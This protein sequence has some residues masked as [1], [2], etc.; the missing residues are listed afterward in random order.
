MEPIV[1]ELEEKYAGEFTIVRV[2]V[3]TSA[4]KALARENGCIGTPAYMLFDDS[5]EQIRRFQGA[6]TSYTFEQEID[7]VLAE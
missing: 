4:G 7:R 6:Q 2:N 3:D 5:G 1:N